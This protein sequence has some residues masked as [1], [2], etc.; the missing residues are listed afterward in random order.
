MISKSKS[1]GSSAEDFAT[2]VEFCVPCLHRLPDCV[3]IPGNTLY[4]AYIP[5]QL[6]FLVFEVS[7]SPEASEFCPSQGKVVDLF[8]GETIARHAQVGAVEFGHG[9]IAL[10]LVVLV[11]VQ[12]TAG[13]EQVLDEPSS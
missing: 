11:P 10:F 12:M 3:R 6:L 8:S 7:L 1:R 9:R 13:F 2:P 4:L 5:Q